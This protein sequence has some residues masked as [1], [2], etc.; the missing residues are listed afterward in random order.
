MAR[1]HLDLLLAALGRLSR[2][3][4]LV[5]PHH[6]RDPLLVTAKLQGVTT[7]IGDFKG[8]QGVIRDSRGYKGLQ[9][10]TVLVTARQPGR[11][12]VMA[13]RPWNDTGLQGSTS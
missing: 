5:Q 6:L 7:V 4:L 2:L 11:Q 8:F 3:R 12:A 1:A 9:G 10:V 13:F